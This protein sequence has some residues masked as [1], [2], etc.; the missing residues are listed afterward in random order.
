MFNGIQ[1]KDHFSTYVFS[2]L[3][4]STVDVYVAACLQFEV[5]IMAT[6]FQMKETKKFIS[7]CNK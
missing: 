1:R 3:V 4:Y 7:I 2:W 5:L 6:R